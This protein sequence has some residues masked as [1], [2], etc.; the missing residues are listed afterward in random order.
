MEF[1]PNMRLRLNFEQAEFI[2]NLD[3]RLFIEYFNPKQFREIP[4]YS[5]T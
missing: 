3:M 2:L 4:F 1:D 5:S